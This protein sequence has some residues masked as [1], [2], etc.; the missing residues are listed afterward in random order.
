MNIKAITPSQLNKSLKYYL[1][2]GFNSLV[3]EGE[4]SGW[5]R[6]GSGHVYFSLKDQTS[7]IRCMMFKRDFFAH[8]IRPKNGDRVQVKGLVTLYEARGDIQ[9]RVRQ[10]QAV[11]SGDLHQAFEAL[12]QKLLKQ[13]L[14]EQHHKKSLPE[15]PGTIAIVTSP[16]AAALQDILNIFRRRYPLLKVR[17]YPT[18]VQG[19]KAYQ[20]IIQALQKAD[21]DSANDLI[22]LTRGG[23]SLEDLWCFNNESL[24]K[25]IFACEHPVVSAVGHETDSCLSDFVADLRAPTPSAAAELVTPDAEVIDAQFVHSKQQLIKTMQSNIDSLSQK[26]DWI[27]SH[28]FKLSPVTR[29]ENGKQN[30]NSLHHQLR[31]NIK[32]QLQ[33]KQAKLDTS[34]GHL[35]LNNPVNQL[36]EKQNQLAHLSYQLKQGMN[37]KIKLSKFHLQRNASTLSALSP[38]NTLERGFSITYNQN[39]EVIEQSDELKAGDLIK[40]RLKDGWINSQV[41]DIKNT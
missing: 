35:Q 16:S 34:T 29:L 11:G 14:F 31:Q 5:V 24:A 36:K 6:P 39:N 32:Y 41:T 2:A 18:Q 13:G 20:S 4:I 1:E 9:I 38:L 22:L 17:I 40:T 27:E 33:L 19:L 30:L 25:A 28:L 12:K 3:I 15:F 8:T 37:H 7:Q 23:G 26:I 21:A 10:I